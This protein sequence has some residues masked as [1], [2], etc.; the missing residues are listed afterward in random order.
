M[1]RLSRLLLLCLLLI[2]ALP[3]AAQDAPPDPACPGAPAPRLIVDGNGRVLPGDS[4][5]VRDQPIKGGM[6]VGAIPGSGE[7]KVLEGPV[8][9]DGL[10]WWR[11]ESGEIAGWTVEG[12][13]ADYWIEP[14][15]PAVSVDI[16]WSNPFRSPKYPVANHMIVGA[17]ARVQTMDGEPLPLYTALDESTPSNELP[18]N[19]LVTLQEEGAGGWWRVES[20]DG[21]AGWVREAI[22]QVGTMA[23]MRPTLAPVC[24]YSENRVLFLAFDSALGSNLYTVG[25]DATHLCNLSYGLQQDFEVYDWSPDGAWIAYSAVVEGS[26]QCAA[27]CSGELYV[28]SVD[29]SVLRRLTFG[30][31]VSHVQWSPDGAWIAAQIDGAEARTRDLRLFAPDGSAERTLLTTDTQFRLMRWSPDGKQLAVI[32]DRGTPVDFWQVIHVID[33][34]TDDSHIAY[35]AEWRLE[36]LSWSPDGAF[37]AAAT[38][39]DTG[40]KVLLEIS[41][42]S[43]EHK[44][45]VDAETRGAVYSMDG[46]QVAFWRTDLGAVRWVEVLDRS[47]GDITRL[48]TLPGVHGRGISWTPEGD[49]LLIGSSGVMRVNIPDGALRSLFVGSFGSNWYPPLVQPG[50]GG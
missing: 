47:T 21:A 4:N 2:A 35:E 29:G 30:Q 38:S 37:L 46:K 15:A 48:A 10:N 39:V 23:G 45:L 31:N 26:A 25:R 43:G 18:V 40:R 24:P 11:V 1:S 42:E 49:A 6:L 8:C 20:E 3:A 16:E 28:E 19:T 36:S 27:G 32:E 13:G 14:L 12:S 33:A 5:N 22:P 50:A 44:V 41:V 17:V 9:A 7:F 34:D